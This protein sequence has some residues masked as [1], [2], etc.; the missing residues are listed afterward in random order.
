MKITVAICTWNRSALLDRTLSEM[1]GLLVPDGI[2]WELLVVNNN[3]TDDTDAVQLR[4][5]A[6]PDPNTPASSELIAW[7]SSI[8]NGSSWL[9]LE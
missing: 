6:V 8:T 2:E 9:W 4:V 1:H 7:V 5:R 3:C